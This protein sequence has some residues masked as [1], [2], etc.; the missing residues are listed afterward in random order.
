MAKAQ[1]IMHTQL[2][3]VTPDT[4]LKEC[5]QILIKNDISGLPVVDRTKRL[6]GIVTEEDLMLTWHYFNRMNTNIAIKD[7]HVHGAPLIIERVIT[8]SENTPLGEIIKTLLYKRIK[9]I[10]I[11]KEGRLIGIVSRRDI[12]KF[13]LS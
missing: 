9:R 12:L 4:S 2:I 11:V 8:A 1:D 3:S 7:C 6:V 13:F 5:I 10:P